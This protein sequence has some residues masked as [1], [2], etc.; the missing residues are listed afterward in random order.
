VKA[1][2]NDPALRAIILD[3]QLKFQEFKQFPHRAVQAGVQGYHAFLR[4][5]RVTYLGRQSEQHIEWFS[6]GQAGRCLTFIVS[7]DV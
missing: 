7:A 4:G 3:N 1:E 2:F 6:G 5:Q